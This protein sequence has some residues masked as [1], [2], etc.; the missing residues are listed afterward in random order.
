MPRKTFCK[1]RKFRKSLQFS[2]KNALLNTNEGRVPIHKELLIKL[3]R[4]LTYDKSK[5]PF[6][7]SHTQIELGQKKMFA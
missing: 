6:S 7:Y 2:N 4:K 5:N 1:E 3:R